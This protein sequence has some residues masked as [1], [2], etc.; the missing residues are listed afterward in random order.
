MSRRLAALALCLPLS[1]PGWAQD[2]IPVTPDNFVRAESDL[3]FGI[4]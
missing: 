1:F 2:A 4:P 3:F